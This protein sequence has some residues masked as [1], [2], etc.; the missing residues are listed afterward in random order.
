MMD[1]CGGAVELTAGRGDEVAKQEE[2]HW[3]TGNKRSSTE[4]QRADALRESQDN[5]KKV[6]Y[7][8]KE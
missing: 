3:E 5:A 1:S 8:I 2:G 7:K 6:R 4:F